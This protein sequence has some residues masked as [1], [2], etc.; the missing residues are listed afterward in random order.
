MLSVINT[1]LAW[2]EDL[3]ENRSNF[4]CIFW[5][6]CFENPAEE[7]ANQTHYLLIEGLQVYRLVSVFI[8]MNY[9][10]GVID[11]W[12]S[13]GINILS[14]FFFFFFFFLGGRVDRWL[15]ISICSYLWEN[16]LKNIFYINAAYKYAAYKK[17]LRPLFVN[18]KKNPVFS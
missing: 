7:M 3:N 9:F 1:P 8:F 2:Y 4:P 5:Q 14:L 10:S 6:H 11:C 12:G 13:N 17:L 16:K 18:L 15:T